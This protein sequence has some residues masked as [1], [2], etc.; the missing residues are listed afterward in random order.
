MGI[1]AYHRGLKNFPFRRKSLAVTPLGDV[2]VV[3][4]PAGHRLALRQIL[5]PEDLLGEDVILHAPAAPGVAHSV[6]AALNAV[7]YRTRIIMTLS[8]IAC[9]LVAEGAGIAVVDQ[10]SVGDYLERGVV[11]RPFNPP[12]VLGTALTFASER[13]VSVAA[14]EFQIAFQSHVKRYL[15]GLTAVMSPDL[16]LA[17]QH[18]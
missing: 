9:T 5:Q 15:T 2:A 8:T 11:I 14:Q 3:A 12:W 1:T 7:A 4:L 10:F 18:C 16:N 13:P 17:T 6:T